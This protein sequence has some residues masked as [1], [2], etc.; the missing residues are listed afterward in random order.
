[1]SSIRDRDALYYPYIHIRDVNWLKAA[2]LC[3]P[4][5]RR[6]VPA[7]FSLNDAS[8]IR[9]FSTLYLDNKPLL[10]EEE[11]Y[12]EEIEA[13]F[14][15]FLSNVE[16]RLDFFRR[17]FAGEVVRTRYRDSFRIH[18]GKMSKGLLYAFER[19]GLAWR[20][21]GGASDGSRWY[22]MHPKLGEAVM[23]T[24]AI[25]VA[26]RWGMDIVTSETHIHRALATQDANQLFEDLIGQVSEPPTIS[27]EEVTDEL[28]LIFLS[29][30]F[31]LEK[32]TPEQ[33]L[34]LKKEKKDLRSFKDKLAAIAERIPEV[35]DAADR[36][37]E[38]KRYAEEIVEE[39][40][41]Y[42]RSLRGFAVEALIDSLKQ[43]IKRVDIRAVA[44]A[45][46][47]GYWLG[48][49]LGLGIGI[50]LY[51]GYKIWKSFREKAQSPY[52]YL[53]NIERAGADR[54]ELKSAVVLPSNDREV[55][56]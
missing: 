34:E 50:A 55:I 18:A 20:V 14:Q 27:R 23:S 2:L 12:S 53:S 8:D 9:P 15:S 39:W 56:K 35:P 11:T 36:A 31:D 16:P 42:R 28:A 3:F 25:T 13:A 22:A 45:S 41:A 24:L 32:L 21:D 47:G 48:G 38:M 17:N 29:T 43:E 6:M 33:I 10:I 7:G 44:S 5:V 26:K 1:M 30:A 19:D 4:H 54:N 40:N 51:G 37:E 52:Q 46:G 49:P